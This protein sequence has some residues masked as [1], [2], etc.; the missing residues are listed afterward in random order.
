MNSPCSDSFFTVGSIS[1][2]VQNNGFFTDLFSCLLLLCYVCVNRLLCQ[3]MP[4]TTVFVHVCMYVSFLQPVTEIDPV[5]CLVSGDHVVG[6]LW[7]ERE[8]TVQLIKLA[9]ASQSQNSHLCRP[10]TECVNREIHRHTLYHTL[11]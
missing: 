4:G 6:D 11:M 9:S 8:C 10:R 1:R 5:C 7:S 2:G 3:M